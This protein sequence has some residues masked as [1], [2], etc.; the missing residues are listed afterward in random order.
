MP[1]N[2]MLPVF[3]IVIVNKEYSPGAME[4]GEKNLLMLAPARLVSVASAGSGFVMPLEV[5]T[6]PVGMVLVRFPF[7]L[8]VTLNVRVQ[9]EFA[10]R[11]PLLNE[12]DPSPGFPINVRRRFLQRN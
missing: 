2:G 9:F 8:V 1:P 10:A 3:W 6:A 5:V 4:F 11:L 7:T 12:K